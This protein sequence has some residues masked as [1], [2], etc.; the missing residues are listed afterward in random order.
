MHELTLKE[1]NLKEN[2][3]KEKTTHNEL[4]YYY[5]LSLPNKC[6]FIPS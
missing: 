3:L 2:A 1:I 4:N 5:L 6:M